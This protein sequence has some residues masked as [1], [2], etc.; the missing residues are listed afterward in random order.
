[1]ILAADMGDVPL[2]TDRQP[3]PGAHFLLTTRYLYVPSS[4]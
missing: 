2:R 1:M 3:D 4:L